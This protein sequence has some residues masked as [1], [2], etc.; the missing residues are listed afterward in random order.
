MSESAGFGADI[1]RGIGKVSA[2]WISACPRRK[3]KSQHTQEKRRALPHGFDL[4]PHPCQTTY[5]PTLPFYSE[6]AGQ[7]VT[8]TSKQMSLSFVLWE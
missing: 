3:R 8:R 1:R 5:L 4:R 7:F 6:N 2:D